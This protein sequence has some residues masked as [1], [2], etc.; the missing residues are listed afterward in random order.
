MAHFAGPT[1]ISFTI[2]LGAVF[3]I[4]KA[5]KTAV[6][7]AEGVLSSSTGD[8][9]LSSGFRRERKKLQKKYADEECCFHN[10]SH[11]SMNA[12]IEVGGNM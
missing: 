12:Q 11:P 2:L 7:I 1:R 9:N 10:V 6:G 4:C 3:G 5:E 8:G